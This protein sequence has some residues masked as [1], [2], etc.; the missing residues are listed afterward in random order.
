MLRLYF[1]RVDPRLRE[2][3]GLVLHF[4]PEPYLR[5]L[6]EANPRL[7]PLYTDYDPN[8]IRDVEG[9]RFAADM[10]CLPLPDNCVDF[11]FCLHVLE[12]VQ[13]DRRGIQNLARVLRP[14]GVA[15]LMVP[16]IVGLDATEDWAKPDPFWFD[17]YRSYSVNDFKSRLSPFE[18]EEVW[19]QDFLTPDETFRYGIPTNSQVLYRCTCR[20]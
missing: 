10:H 4:A 8:A 13:D 15:Y 3:S 20:A 19:P 6:I 12:H 5:T 9:N 17:H 14:G 16:F 1:D 7:C 18:Y 11:I 2:G